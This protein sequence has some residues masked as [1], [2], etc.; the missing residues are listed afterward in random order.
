MAPNLLCVAGAFTFGWTG[1]AAVII[2]N[3]GTSMVYDRARRSLRGVH[4][5]VAGQPDAVWCEDGNAAPASP[6][7]APGK[8][9]EMGTIS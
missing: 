9:L 7:S 4:D 5:L 6:I 2:S 1:L 3:F 8:G